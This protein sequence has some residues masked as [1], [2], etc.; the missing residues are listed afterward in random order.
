MKKKRSSGALSV[1]TDDGG[2]FLPRQ[3]SLSRSP[4]M[5]RYNEG[6]QSLRST[7]RSHQKTAL[8]KSPSADSI[9]SVPAPP[10]LPLHS[11]SED[12]EGS[13]PSRPHPTV[14]SLLYDVDIDEF[15]S[16]DDQTLD[17][18]TLSELDEIDK[19][20]ELKDSP[21]SSPTRKHPQIKWKTSQRALER[22]PS[23]IEDWNDTP[24]KGDA[25]EFRW[26]RKVT[27]EGN[28]LKQGTKR[29]ALGM[30]QK[31]WQKR[32]VC[33]GEGFI[34]WH[35]SKDADR[36]SGRLRLV[37]YKCSEPIRV[38]N[39]RVSLSRIMSNKG[40]GYKFTLVPDN[41]E[42]RELKLIAT[43][44]ESA[45]R[46]TATIR[47]EI[48]AMFRDAKIPRVRLN[49]GYEDISPSQTFK[50]EKEAH[51]SIKEKYRSRIGGKEQKELGQGQFAR[52][53]LVERIKDQKLFAC[54]N[55]I[56]NDMVSGKSTGGSSRA[57]RMN[58]LDEIEILKKLDHPNIVKLIDVY[59]VESKC[60]YM[61]LSY[62]DGGTLEELINKSPSGFLSESQAIAITRELLSAVWYVWCSSVEFENVTSFSCFNYITLSKPQQKT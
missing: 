57:D 43:S 19:D 27:I 15:E 22:P 13:L 24:K 25:D 50:T 26:P 55:F 18:P 9:S 46:W 30:M 41:L 10:P 49:S 38:K 28:L 14:E 37:H 44:K 6:M 2:G 36:P 40:G 7:F 23:E 51:E 60:V 62:C 3:M 33:V 11:I 16:E 47:T 56:L 5:R 58:V 61:F 32:Y 45:S 17:L 34:C 53:W 52:V 31:P 29:Y 20:V 12:S 1:D 48:M 39:N 21:P 42:R 4:S 54:K 8:E 35:K 59:I